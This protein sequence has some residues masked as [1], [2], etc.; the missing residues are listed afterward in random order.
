MERQIKIEQM[1]SVN[2]HVEELTN[3]LVKVVDEDASIG[4]LPPLST[5]VA[6]EYWECLLTPGVILWVAKIDNQIAGS[7][8][9]HLCSKQNGTHRAEIAKLMT[10]PN[11]RRK[12]VARILMKTAE[13]RA[14]LEG[15]S[16]LVLD[17]RE[18][19]PSNLLYT[20]LGYI[21]VGRIPQFAKSAS[22]ELDATILYY[23]NLS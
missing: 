16:L 19:D 10:H 2:D 11:F 23:K 14:Q 4:F 12:G 5:S 15:R 8:Q 21:Q 18:G 7:I 9:L 1:Y 3:L 22:G 6:R 13:E 17:T 20:S